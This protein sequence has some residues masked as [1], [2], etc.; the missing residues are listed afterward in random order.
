VGSLIES[1]PDVPTVTLLVY[2]PFAPNVPAV[3]AKAAD[4]PVLS[5]FS[6]TESLDGPPSLWAEH[7]EVVP[8]VSEVKFCVPHPESITTADWASV[9]VQA[10][11]TLLVYQPLEPAVPVM[12][13]VITGGVVSQ[14][15]VTVTLAGAV[16]PATS[17]ASAL[18]VFD[19]HDKP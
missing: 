5:I 10:T 3:T 4:G 11:D 1:D 15:R 6:E 17:V 12:T 13:F 7:E 14:T 9:T 18:I 16:L 8:V 2:Q 19:P